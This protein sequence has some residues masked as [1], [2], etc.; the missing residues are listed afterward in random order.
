MG[1]NLRTCRRALR[2]ARPV[3]P[4]FTS[5]VVFR[6][7][8]LLDIVCQESYNAKHRTNR[9]RNLA[10]ET[11]TP[12]EM[13]RRLVAFDTTSRESNLELIGF[14]ADYLKGH[15]VDSVLTHDDE[16]RKANLFATLGGNGH[17][18]VA[19]SGHTDVVPVDG[20]PWDTDP[21][22]LV[23][24]NGRL[25]GRGTSDMKTFSAI[26]LA[27][28][29]EFLH[30][31]L[32][33]P[34]HIALSYD[35]E[36]GCIGVQRLID[37]IGKTG[38]KPAIVIIGEPTG[39][40]VVNAH[41]GIYAFTTTVTGHEAH[42]SATHIGVNAVMVAA[43]LIAF[44]NDLAEEMKSRGDPESG[45]DPP[46]TTVH[47]GVIAGGTALNIIPRHCQFHWEFRLMP[48]ADADEIIDRFN[49]FAATIESRLRMVA[50]TA[51]IHTEVGAS[52][53]G[54]EPEADARAERFVMALTGDNRAGKIS[55]GTEGGRF[56]QAGM[57]VVVCGPGHIT[58]AHKPNE[59]ID[60]EQ[61]AACTAF[62]GRLMDRL[63]EPL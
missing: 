33:A 47:V 55:F 56:Q 9:V 42:S 23:E 3:L 13:L 4:G 7:Q 27:F 28:V 5:R 16:R 54:L 51:G 24:R 34:V 22:S 14:V 44:L 49:A 38:V 57:S 35:E 41:K 15:G 60:A 31:R 48:G 32:H 39:M 2:V 29:P 50:E 43:E 36:V 19:L 61:V 17:G 26:A 40:R 11:Y 62:M 20:Q 25:Y 58:Q 1:H 21:F 45:F 18:G 46:Y 30:R 8:L 10:G 6:P 12:I 37:Q 52:V 53:P 63:E 59:F